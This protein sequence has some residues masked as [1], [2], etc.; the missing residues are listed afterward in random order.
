MAPATIPI[1]ATITKKGDGLVHRP[2][3][4]R[5]RRSPASELRAPNTMSAVH[6]AFAYLIDPR[7]PKN[8]GTVRPV[9]VIASRDDR[10]PNPP[11]PVTL[12]TNHCAQDIA[13][14]IIKGAGAGGAGARDRRLGTALP[15][16]HQGRQT[17]ARSA[18]S[19]GT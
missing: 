8:S 2:Q 3:R 4:R 14:S 12:S 15:H 9:K 7:T 18:R 6:M 1:R 13:E 16:R 17:R 10:H 11:A 5:R 19:S